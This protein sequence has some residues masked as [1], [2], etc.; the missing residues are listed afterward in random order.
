MYRYAKLNIEHLSTTCTFFI[1]T[2]WLPAQIIIPSCT[3]FLIKICF[4]YIK[5]FYYAIKAK[6]GPK[7]G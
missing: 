3:I 2:C 6:R 1:L 5:P 4:I 7:K